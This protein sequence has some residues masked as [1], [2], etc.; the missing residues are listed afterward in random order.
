[1]KIRTAVWLYITALA[2]TFVVILATTVVS[3]NNTKNIQSSWDHFELTRSEKSRVLNKIHAQIG[4]GGMIH[5]YK[6]L[7]LREDKSLLSKIHS[8]LGGAGATISEYKDLPLNELELA[9]INDIELTFGK[10]RSAL[11]LI[12]TKLARNESVLIIDNV[13]RIN[14]R[15]ALEGF[16]LLAEELGGGLSHTESRAH[17]LNRL[18][19]ELGYGGMIHNYK[20]YLLRGESRYQQ[21]AEENI[22]RT[23]MA[24]NSY[25]ENSLV[26]IEQ[27]ALKDIDW[28]IGQYKNKLSIIQQGIANGLSSREIDRQVKVD[29]APLLHGLKQLDREIIAVNEL[30]A[31]QLQQSLTS[32]A[33]SNKTII[34]IVVFFSSLLTLGFFWLIHYKIIRPLGTLAKVTTELSLEQA[35]IDI[36]M[37]DKQNEIGEL[38]VSLDIFRKNILR[39]QH[40]EEKLKQINQHLEERILE[41]VQTADLN[42]KHLENLLDNAA[43]AI[44]IANM[45][46]YILSY[47]KAAA[48]LFG[49]TP[50]EA[51]GKNT[52][53]LM[54]EEHARHHDHYVDN[55]IATEKG[56]IMGR[57]RL[58]YG[59]HKS[60]QLFPI[61]VSLSSIQDGEQIYMT[62]IIRDITQQQEQENKL[63]QSQK[64]EAMGKLTGGIA[65]D[66]NNMLGVILGFTELLGEVSSDKPQTDRYIEHIRH[67]AQRGVKL[68]TKL[69]KF[70][71]KE[72]MDAELVDINQLLS[73][74]QDMLE[75]IL[76]AKIK[77]NMKLS[78]SSCPAWIDVGEMEDAILNLSINAMHAMPD[79]GQLDF[80]TEIVELTSSNSQLEKGK[81]I[82][83][84]VTDTGDGIP[85][86]LQDKIFEPFFSTKA[87]KGTGLGLSQVYGFAQRSH[88]QI[89]LESR[90]QLGTTFLLYLP[91]YTK[92]KT[93]HAVVTRPLATTNLDGN[94]TIL[95]VDDEP[96]LRMLCKDILQQHG[97]HIVTAENGHEAQQLIQQQAFQLVISDVIMPEVDGYA[98]TAWLQSHYPHIRV[99]LISGYNETATDNLVD[100]EIKARILKK[101]FSTHELLNTVRQLLDKE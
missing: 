66:Y 33:T 24:L 65:H 84:S 87:D 8:D 72:S 74:Q 67:A 5:H 100:D 17:I 11:A 22:N 44:V 43:D 28:V 89:R 93:N 46:G 80:K 68:T 71:R 1:M 81:Y 75:R 34:Y 53:L 52:K 96:A 97:Y 27:S 79:G 57:G 42:A 82:V 61:E 54:P 21:A 64:M 70:S 45:N 35:D 69:L 37:L 62:A 73:E 9:A 30:A 90:Q 18:R 83:I 13:A 16:R 41:A 38:A 19:T 26:A 59:K 95:V 60:G 47:N 14:D 25:R 49:Y 94:E 91:L 32:V 76:T 4:F 99:Q 7:I 48:E 78:E 77:L 29:D 56:K 51:I 101:P 10:Y 92:D 98:L 63:R 40:A 85:V 88:G 15:P 36:P 86:E 58:L 3:L 31:S 12:E 23:Q 2:I 39:R 20:S 50:D 55:Y 6:N